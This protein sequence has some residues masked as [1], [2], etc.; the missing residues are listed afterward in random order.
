MSKLRARSSI[1]R[2]ALDMMHFATCCLDII[3]EQPSNHLSNPEDPPRSASRPFSRPVMAISEE[4]L[5]ILAEIRVIERRQKDLDR[6]GE[7]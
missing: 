6:L 2:D 1:L 7:T 4:F 5:E 3:T